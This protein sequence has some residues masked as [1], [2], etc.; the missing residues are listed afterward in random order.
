MS[1]KHLGALEALDALGAFMETLKVNVTK[2]GEEGKATITFNGNFY[3]EITFDP[4]GKK[5][6]TVRL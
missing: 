1:D 6:L 4:E 3:A 5:I 2:E